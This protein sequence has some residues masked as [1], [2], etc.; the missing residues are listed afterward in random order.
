MHSKG[1]IPT[2]PFRADSFIE[3]D[4][5]NFYRMPNSPPIAPNDYYYYSPRREGS[6][7]SESF[8]SSSRNTLYDTSPLPPVPVRSTSYPRLEQCPEEPLAFPPTDERMQQAKRALLEASQRP[9]KLLHTGDVS[10]KPDR[11]LLSKTKRAYFVLTHHHLL[12][13][14]TSQ[15]AHTELDCTEPK[16]DKHRILL[17]LENIYAIQAVITASNTCRIDHLHPQSNQTL[18]F[19]FHAETS[20]ECKEWIQALRSAVSIHHPSLQT[21]SS[22][23]RYSALDRVSKQKDVFEDTDEMRMFKV[24]F[25]EKRF[26]GSD[27][28][29]E[30]FLPVILVF[31]KYSFYLLPASVNDDEYLKTV[32]RDRFGYL[33]IESVRYDGSDDT[34]C[35][36][37]RQINRRSRQLVFASTFCQDIVR[38]FSRSIQ[39]ILH[40]PG[41]F[42]Y[43]IPKELKQIKIMP[44]DILPDPE[45]DLTG[46]DDEDMQAF[47]IVLRAYTAALNLN[48]SRF[49]YSMEGPLGRKRFVLLPPNEINASPSVY[50]KYE[51]LA[52][53][54]TIQ[55]NACFHEVC[56]SGHPLD[57]L[58]N[59]KMEYNDGWSVYVNAILKGSVLSNELDLLLSSSK[60]LRK[61]DLSCCSMGSPLPDGT[62]KVSSGLTAIGKAMQTHSTHLSRLN[63]GQNKI[64]ES[65]FVS[66]MHG[67]QRHKK[68]M[69][70]LALNDCGLNAGQIEMMLKTLFEKNP[71]Q[72]IHLDL[73][74]DKEVA[75]SPGLISRIIPT[76]KRLE[77]L[78]MRGYDL[79]NPSYGFDLEN[80]RL[81]LLD[82][83]GFRLSRETISRICQ[84]ILQP[85]FR[86][87]EALYLARCA[88]NGRNVHELLCSISRS[89]NRQMHLDLAENPI[90]KE[91]IHLPKF[92]SAIVQGEGPSSISFAGTEWDDSNLCEFIDCLRDNQTITHLSL[93]DIKI[94]DTKEISPDTVHMLSSLFERNT[95]IREL[96]LDYDKSKP[97]RSS[98]GLTEAKPVLGAAVAQALYGL[99]HN[100]ILQH[101]NVSGLHLGDAGALALSRALKTNRALKS[102]YLDDNSMTIEGYRHLG[103]VIQE[104]AVQV[105]DL[106]IP[107]NDLRFQLSHLTYRIEELV[108]SQNEAQFFLIH[109]VSG[110]KKRAKTHELEML[111]QEQ[112]SCELALKN[113]VGVVNTLMVSVQKN[114]RQFEEQRDRSIELQL[115]A[116]T[117]AQELAVAQVRLQC[118]SV[119]RSSSSTNSSV[120]RKSSVSSQ[121]PR[122]SYY[123]KPAVKP[124]YFHGQLPATPF[125]DRYESSLL[126]PPLASYTDDPGFI[127]DFGYVDDFELEDDSYLYYPHK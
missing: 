51:L 89:D 101:L 61:L 94:R 11:G 5:E 53:F 85:S 60:A 1:S 114:I 81:R 104:I 12:A 7:S 88:L 98:F 95:T 112:K 9:F 79:L 120:Y 47:S 64:S 41:I 77:S 36:Q 15:K 84:W 97:A 83:S 105:I 40:R 113:I 48:K 21:V 110:D 71:E 37:V 31:G 72:M 111:A 121:R 92:Y 30:F 20:K 86:T 87:M 126:S 38:Y 17:N 69:K 100:C 118:R 6:V 75:L 43:N 99:R 59:W 125:V 39:S 90:M 4:H 45:D 56:F 22:P 54:R 33:S 74:S 3:E 49:Q 2:R 80:S 19:V 25:K 42:E 55:S 67:I 26:K 127:E 82:V 10:Y 29:R 27:V 16:V 102:I 13:Y 46:Q 124:Y 57:S 28:P 23:E 73:S 76:L 122:P 34:V 35:I 106:P 78:R 66:L 58:E 91:V 108:L 93:S 62:A 109:T 50:Q 52:L 14:K 123:T 119:S 8:A 44:I 107:R 18:S 70:E 65:D 103:K 116:Q 117:A 68:S 63:L 32:E 96:Q 115:Q 24:V